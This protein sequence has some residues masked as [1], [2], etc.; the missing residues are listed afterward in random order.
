[1]FL[2]WRSDTP[3]RGIRGTSF[4]GYELRNTHMLLQPNQDLVWLSSE[5]NFVGCP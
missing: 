3:Q 2:Q 1:M 5:L 4:D